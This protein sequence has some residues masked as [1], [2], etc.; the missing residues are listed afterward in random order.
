MRGET[1]ERGRD[2][3]VGQRGAFVEGGGLFFRVSYFSSG[4]ASG[5]ND[6][7]GEGRDRGDA[8]RRASARGERARG[9][10][11]A[12]MVGG[13]GRTRDACAAT[14]G[15]R[16]RR[17]GGAPCLFE[18]ARDF[19]CRCALR[20]SA[21]DDRS[22]SESGPSHA[23]FIAPSLALPPRVGSH[24]AARRGPTRGRRP[25]RARGGRTRGGRGASD[26]RAREVGCEPARAESSE[27]ASAH[28]HYF[29]FPRARASSASARRA[30]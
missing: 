22:A 6:R 19:S 12:G 24:V 28:Y 25:K 4:A 8:T 13:R 1:G 15:V 2:R 9:N 26:A 11:R 20:A 14:A 16:R 29:P 10:A 18:P 27:R 21:I 23:I 5:A 3:S 7:A 17:E 30:R